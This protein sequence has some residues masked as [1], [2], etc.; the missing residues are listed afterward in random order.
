[1]KFY[2][3]SYGIGKKAGELKRLARGR[4]IGLIL[5]ALD[6]VKPGERKASNEKNLKELSSLGLD[7]EILDLKDYFGKKQRLKEKIDTLGGVWV[8][9]G[10]TFVLRQAMKLSGFDKIIKNLNNKDFLYGGYSAGICVLAPSLE[11]L[12]QVDDPS[13]MPYKESKETVWEGLGMLDYIILPHYRSDHP[14][15]AD[16]D[17]EVEFC[18][19]NKIPFKTLRDGEVIVIE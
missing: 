17:K 4:K 11:A 19:K 12:Q 1:M 5:N 6:H 16:I 9:G 3:S 15:S 8:R 13:V 2:L 18:K 14:E 7:V 10:N